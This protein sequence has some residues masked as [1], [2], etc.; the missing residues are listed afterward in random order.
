MGH[1]LQNMSLSARVALVFAAIAVLTGIMTGIVAHNAGGLETLSRDVRE[2]QYVAIHALADMQALAE[3][4]YA[5]KGHSMMTAD[6]T[7]RAM[8]HAEVETIIAHYTTLDRKLRSSTRDIDM[9]HIYGAID[10]VWQTQTKNYHA[11]HTAMGKAGSA[12]GGHEAYSREDE[13]I[14]RQYRGHAAELEEIQLAQLQ[15][16]SEGI[17]HALALMRHSVLL[18][19]IVL[20]GLIIAGFFMI[21]RGVSQPVQQL[22]Q[23][24]TQ[25][26]AG[27]LD[28]AVPVQNRHDEIGRMAAALDV[29]RR[30][31]LE[32]R[33][34]SEEKIRRAEKVEA[35]LTSFD[36]SVSGVLKAVAAAATEL[37]STAGEM[38]AVARETGKQAQAAETS[39]RSTSG[40]VETVAAATEEINASLGEIS[41]QATRASHIVDETV[42]KAQGTD[43][44][45]QTLEEAA[46]KIGDIVQVISDIAEQ[47]NLLA[48]NAAIEAARAGDAGRGFAVVAAEVKSLAGQTAAATKDISAQISGIQGSTRG[49]AHAIRGILGT[50]GSIH[51]AA[52]SIA[53]AV[54]EQTAATGEIA[55]SVTKAARSA[56]GVS[57]NVLSLSAAAMRTDSAAGQVLSAARELSREAEGLKLRVGRFFS[58]LRGAQ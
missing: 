11:Q 35:I 14:M 16:T 25:M 15:E 13:D 50:I 2:R 8:A 51:N 3:R 53:G 43:A 17:D 20:I 45:V 24:M 38:N 33:R 42:K 10:A 41:R 6:P 58:D 12:Q 18:A 39:S 55:Q 5:I 48:L 49:A 30:N 34:L 21:V 27:Q 36:A 32:A 19:Q 22:T 44:L 4:L 47:T 46:Q 29:F 23:L 57:E 31:S 37:E 28:T 26:S 56:R 9:Q 52:T 40:N 1:M 54:D 7:D